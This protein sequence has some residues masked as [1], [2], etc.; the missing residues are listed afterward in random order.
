MSK[1]SRHIWTTLRRGPTEA[2]YAF[3]RA[4]RRRRNLA[5]EEPQLRAADRD[6]DEIEA[7]A[8]VQRTVA[9]L[10]AR[11]IGTVQWFFPGFHHATVGAGIGR[12][13]GGGRVL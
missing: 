6:L 8:K 2:G 5:D 13:A 4:R 7:N 9:A 12:A 10:D 1:R 3:F 11:D